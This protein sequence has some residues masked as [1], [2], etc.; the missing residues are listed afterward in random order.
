MTDISLENYFYNSQLKRSFVQFM[1][2]FSGL[3]V[4]IGKN[5]FDSVTNL[6]EV[7]I[8]YGSRD[9][10]V[11]YIFQEQTQNKMLRLP[12]MSAAMTSIR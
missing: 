5:K 3:K 1:A 10:V 7:P 6:I 12:T 4:S 8:V 9:R 11:S 2:I